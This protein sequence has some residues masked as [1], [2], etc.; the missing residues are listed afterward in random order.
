[1]GHPWVL[2]SQI[3]RVD[4]APATGDPV[5]VVSAAGAFLG[6]GLYHES[7]LIRVR[8]LTRQPDVDLDE[9]LATRI[10]DAFAMRRAMFPD[11]EHWR[12]VNG[13]ADGIPGTVIDRYG[14][15]LVFSTICAGIERRKDALLDLLQEID[16]PRSL[17]QRDDNWLRAKDGLPEVRAVVRGEE[18]GPVTLEEKS[19]RF[20]IDVLGGPKTGFF[21]DQRFHRLA[22]RRFA[23]GRRVLDLFS[24]DG[25]FGLHAAAGGAE[26]AELVDV[27]EPALERARANASASGL[28]DRIAY[29][30]A[31]LLDELPKWANERNGEFDL[32]VLDPP[33][34][35]KSRRHVDSATRAYQLLNINALRLL[36]PGGIL[37]TSSCSAALDE[38][39]WEKMLRYAIRKA[40]CRVRLLYRGC[41]P[42]DHPVLPEMP[43]TQYLKFRVVQ[44]LPD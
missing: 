10:R 1:K 39:T 44:K 19:V 37:A 22:V 3:G 38:T 8:L 16:S 42:P 12:A 4:G 27:S 32:I 40:E 18:P 13:E 26:S 21:L 35:A 9:L 34:F 17:V 25:G 20:T 6:R 14:D 41:Q 30:A 31:D 23:R 2:G 29:R 15:V 5:D 43:E 36:P 11:S 33:A 7:S 24:S 28:A